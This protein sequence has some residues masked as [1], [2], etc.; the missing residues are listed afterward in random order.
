M[1]QTTSTQSQVSF[2]ASSPYAQTK[3]IMRYVNYLD[4]WKAIIIPAQLSDI[5]YV[6]EHKYTN[7]PDLLSFD[8]YKTDKYWWVFAMRNPDIISDPIYDL[9]AGITI[10]LPAITSLPATGSS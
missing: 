10:Y 9:V 7:R 2:A 4:F 5:E 8:I 3:Q 1:S 6:V